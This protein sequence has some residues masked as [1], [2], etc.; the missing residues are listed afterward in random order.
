MSIN[1]LEYEIIEPT[2]LRPWSRKI[3]DIFSTK[4]NEHEVCECGEERFT[5]HRSEV[6][7]H[8][9]ALWERDNFFQIAKPAVL[10][11]SSNLPVEFVSSGYKVQPFESVKL[12]IKI[13]H[14]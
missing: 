1:E 10:L 14:S 8:D 12:K 11:T 3:P 6:H 2:K 4:R 13:K 5:G 7:I 9:H